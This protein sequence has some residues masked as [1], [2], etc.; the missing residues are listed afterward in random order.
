MVPPKKKSGSKTGGKPKAASPKPQGGGKASASSRSGNRK[1]KSKKGA[2]TGKRIAFAFILGLFL[3][4]AFFIFLKPESPKGPKS[5]QT[6]SRTEKG[7]ISKSSLPRIPEEKTKK[8]AQKSAPK[9]AESKKPVFPAPDRAVK[10]QG[11]SSS[12]A[13]SAKEIAVKGQ[14]APVTALP[15]PAEKHGAAGEMPADRKPQA[16]SKERNATAGKTIAAALVDLKQLP[17]EESL[18][19][20]IQDQVR[21]VDYALIQAARLKKLSAGAM[22]QI[23][24]EDRSKGK[25]HY[26]F[27]VIEVLPGP[28]ADVYVNSVRECLGAWAEKARLRKGG[29]KN[30]WAVFINGVQTHV[31]QLY[32][33]KTAFPPLSGTPPKAGPQEA[34]GVDKARLR[35]PGEPA[36]L[37]IVMDDLG[38]SS[39]ALQRL[40]KL[41]FPVTCAFWP[42][43]AYTKEGA[44]AAHAAGNEIL[45]H[46]PMEPLGY[47]KV[48]PGPN[49]L[50][51]GM[52]ES[53]IREKVKKSLEAVPF[54]VGLNNHM[55]SRF[56]QHS[57]EV[58]AVLYLLRNRGLFMLDSVTHGRSIFADRARKLGVERYRRN[59][60]LDVEATRES[61][62]A[63]LRQAERIALLTGQAIAIGHPLPE[64]LAA[65]QEWQHTRNKEVRVVRLRDLEQE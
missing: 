15:S 65:L 3:A 48:K 55:G 21:Q 46:Q 52:D 50:L 8:A 45:V 27:Q 62:L 1:K 23:R 51:V 34:K 25:E 5:V 17:Y 11:K 20:H 7:V 56:T 35:Q 38:A 57:R 33:G 47:P 60:F 12:E 26:H 41:N 53:E 49:V 64:T 9:S 54:A 42:H 59:I 58:D 2:D 24:M 4:S 10:S 39:K 28:S 14:S 61:V 22:R 36:K 18:S 30:Q 16:S 29:K 13:A 37:V 32:P 31:L 6:V 19:A 44:R 43:G 40:M 63:Q